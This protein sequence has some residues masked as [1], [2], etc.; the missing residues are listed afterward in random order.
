MVTRERC[1]L[2]EFCRGSSNHGSRWTDACPRLPR[3][4]RRL[5]RWILTPRLLLYFAWSYASRHTP[6]KRREGRVTER[7][8]RNAAMRCICEPTPAG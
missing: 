1:A 4:P 7:F 8:P 6:P 3:V 5:G 2:S